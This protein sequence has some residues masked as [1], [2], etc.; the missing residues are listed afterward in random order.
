MTAGAGVSQILA[1]NVFDV[2]AVAVT[3]VL[4]ICVATNGAGGGWA[5]DTA[6]SN[7]ARGTG[8]SQLD[9]TTRPYI[10]NKNA[11]TNCYE[12]TTNRSAVAT[13]NKATYLGTFY[14]VNNG[15]TSSNSVWRQSHTAQPGLFGLWNAYN[16]VDVIRD[17]WPR[18]E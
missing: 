11:L 14:S 7:T 6:G 13:A 3:G 18:N 5:S 2:W 15:Q 4:H 9:T 16:R 12:G 10:T 1:A 17:R 8:Y